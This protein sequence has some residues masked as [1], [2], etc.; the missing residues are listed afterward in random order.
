M[1]SKERKKSM[2]DELKNLDI[3]ESDIA[4]FKEFSRFPGTGF[5]SNIQNILSK[6]K[7]H[8]SIK[9]SEEDDGITVNCEIRVYFGVNIPQLCY[10]IQTKVKQDIEAGGELNVKAVNIRIDGIDRQD[11]E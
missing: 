7:G 6:E 1:S 3:I 8:P 10:D 5:T 4:S 9:I 11:Q 2:N